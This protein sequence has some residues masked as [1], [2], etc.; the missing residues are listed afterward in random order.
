M[1]KF[2]SLIYILFPLNALSADPY[3]I[4]YWAVG[5]GLND[6]QVSLEGT[7]LSFEKIPSRT[8][9]KEI[10]ILETDNLSSTPMVIGG[11]K[12][13]VEQY[14]WVSDTHM[15]VVFSQQVRKGIEGFNQGVFNYKTALLNVKTQKFKELDNDRSVGSGKRFATRL[16]DIL[17]ERKDEV[18][19]S[20]AEAQRGQ[21]FKNPAY[22]IYNFKTD[23]KRLILRSSGEYRGI[24]FDDNAV[25]ISSTGFDLQTNEYIWYYRPKGTS[26]W[27]EYHRMHEDS[28]EDFRVL[29]T[30][31]F[32]DDIY[33]IAQNGEDKSSLWKYNPKQKRFV[34]KIF[35][36]KEADLNGPLYHYNRS[37]YPD[38]LI[39]VTKYTDKYRRIYFS[40]DL[41]L[42][43][44]AL[45]YQLESIIPNAYQV[46][47]ISSSYDTNT[48][49]VL[50]TAPNDPG[51]YYLFNNNSFVKIGEKKPF[52][53]SED[54]ASLE[55]IKYQSSDGLMI[56]A[57]LH[58]PKGEGPFPLV[59]MPHGGPFVGESITYDTWPQ[60]FANNGY[61]VLQP[62]YRGSYGYGIEFHKK[63]FNNGGQGG[64][65][66]QDDADWGAIDLIKKGR[67][68]KDNIFM[69]GW[70][71][72]GYYASIAATN[73]NNIYSC[74]IAGAPVTDLDQQKG[75]YL[76]QLRGA[77]EIQQ[78]AYF[79]GSISPIDVVEDVSIPI[80]IV[81]GD[82]DQ[83]VPVKHA[84]K[85]ADE[86]KKYGK[87][88]KLVILENADH[89]SNTLTYDHYM[90]LYS[91]SLSFLD[92]CKK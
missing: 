81:H 52:L 33:V 35:G 64:L 68:D 54:L 28:F 53:K 46:S 34:K 7:Y 89:F 37:K 9:P 4:E 66:M 13:D 61:M 71:N 59:V 8:S 62:Q 10:H 12:M 1:K 19:I 87:D 41:S 40:G 70:S 58:V 49:V 79:D 55:Y 56:P 80:L 75:Y 69:F 44:E 25:P 22:Y 72:G 30:N 26:S 92:S 88:H 84:Y 83:R 11:T 48:F 17:P 3:P 60:M 2:L 18:I 77:Q 50:N 31:S 86:L 57:Y 21:S 16:V 6:V 76:S 39:G 47:I 67:V 65:L 27:V 20:Y 91:E 24:R 5:N 73:K 15:V 14:Y 38:S 29:R 78:R 32:E 85:Y 23:K 63:A 45:Y 82:N 42:E 74:V 90:T 36:F 43:V 51:T